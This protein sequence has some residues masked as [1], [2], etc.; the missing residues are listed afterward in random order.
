MLRFG[1]RYFDKIDR[2]L[3]ERINREMEEKRNNNKKRQV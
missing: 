1:N 3:T 2:I